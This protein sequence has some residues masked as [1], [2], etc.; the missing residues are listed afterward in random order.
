M[1]SRWAIEPFIISFL[2]ALIILSL[3][4]EQGVFFGPNAKITQVSFHIDVIQMS[5]SSV[6]EIDVNE[7]LPRNLRQIVECVLQWLTVYHTHTKLSHWHSNS[8]TMSEFR[9]ISILA[10]WKPN[11]HSEQPNWRKQHKHM[12]ETNEKRWYVIEENRSIR[13]RDQIQ[14][15]K[16]GRFRIPRLNYLLL[17]ICVCV[18]VFVH[19]FICSLF[20]WLLLTLVALMRKNENRLSSPMTRK[21]FMCDTPVYDRKLYCLSQANDEWMNNNNNK[22]STRNGSVFFWFGRMSVKLLGTHSHISIV[23]YLRSCVWP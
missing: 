11:Q 5:H 18:C 3:F 12:D 8:M 2:F 20:F 10:P 16:R 7:A 4:L 14:R 9:K 1:L 13:F 21:W 6:R 17:R 22:R 15:Q 23:L 19:T